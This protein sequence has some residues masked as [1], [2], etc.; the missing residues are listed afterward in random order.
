MEPERK[1]MM[2]KKRHGIESAN[3]VIGGLFKAESEQI[4]D[5]EDYF[6]KFLSKD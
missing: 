3:N 5:H 1:K 4:D 2:N 6:G